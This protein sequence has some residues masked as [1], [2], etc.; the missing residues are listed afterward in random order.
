MSRSWRRKSF[1]NDEFQ[2]RRKTKFSVETLCSP[3][4][5]SSPISDFDLYSHYVYSYVVRTGPIF[6]WSRFGSGS[7]LMRI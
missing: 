5:K 6:I 2:F 3:S 1:E 4:H 7:Y